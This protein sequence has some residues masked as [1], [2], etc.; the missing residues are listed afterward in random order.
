MQVCI[1]FEDGGG[2]SVLHGLHKNMIAVVVIEDHQV[3]ISSTG[4]GDESSSLIGVNLSSGL[5]DG[6]ETLEGFGGISRGC[7]V[8]G[9]MEGVSTVRRNEGGL[10]S[11]ALVHPCLIQ[12]AFRH[13]HGCGRKF[14][15][16][17]GSKSREVGEKPLG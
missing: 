12:V 17:L 5:G 11:G 10:S 16:G 13:G 15:K 3:I 4:W 8:I 9:T 14:A 2:L 1:G 7:E 6:A